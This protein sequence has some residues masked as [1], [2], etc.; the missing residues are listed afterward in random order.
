MVQPSTYQYL[1][2][3]VFIRVDRVKKPLQ[4]PYNGPF[5]VIERMDKYFIIDVNGKHDSIS[6]DRLKVA[7]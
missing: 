1:S 5:R 2:S 7:P 4:P 6:I 3:H